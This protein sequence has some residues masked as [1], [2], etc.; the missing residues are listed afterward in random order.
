MIAENERTVEEQ[1]ASLRFYDLA[2]DC[3]T[4]AGV[5]LFAKE[6]LRWAPGA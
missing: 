6:P 1:M 2:A 4:N 5:L 3:P